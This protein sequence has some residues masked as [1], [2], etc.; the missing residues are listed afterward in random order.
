MQKTKIVNS[1][2]AILVTTVQ[3]KLVFVLACAL[4]ICFI[5][6]YDFNSTPFTPAPLKK[7]S[8]TIFD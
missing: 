3:V 6:Y 2:L 5:L 8:Q 4:L 1:Y 7:V